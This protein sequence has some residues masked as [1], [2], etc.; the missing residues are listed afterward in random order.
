MKIRSNKNEG[1]KF[2][3]IIRWVITA[4]LLSFSLFML[5]KNFTINEVTPSGDEMTGGKVSFEMPNA[6]IDPEAIASTFLKK[7]QETINECAGK[8]MASIFYAVSQLNRYF[9]FKEEGV[10]ALLED[11]FKLGSKAKMAYYFVQGNGRLENYLN[12]KTENYLGSPLEL[13][14]EVHRVTD[15]LKKDL[16]RNHNQL[17]LTLEADLAALP[18]SLKI[19][20]SNSVAFVNDFNTAF[21]QTL[22]GM[23]PRTVGTQLGVEA[24]SLAVDAWVAPAIGVMIV[25]YLVSR[26]IISVGVVAAEGAALSAGAANGWWTFG[27]S[28][29]VGVIIA[30]V[31]DWGCNKVAKADAEKKIKASLKAWREGTVSAFENSTKNGLDLFHKSRKEALNKSLIHTIGMLAKSHYAG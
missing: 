23:L 21:D 15:A 12:K 13:K 20:N 30:A 31:I 10:E 28:I 8:D 16:E 4:V 3:K 24:V 19:S 22:R 2:F 7:H 25:E 5:V 18:F 9:D 6:K 17:M 27:T 26:G 11:L 29:V 14:N 1:V